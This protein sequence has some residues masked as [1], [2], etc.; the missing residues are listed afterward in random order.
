MT[1]TV[2]NFFET[3]EDLSNQLHRIDGIFLKNRIGRILAH[4]P[5][6]STGL[7]YLPLFLICAGVLC[8]LQKAEEEGRLHG[9]KIY[10]NALNVSLVVCR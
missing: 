1:G 4:R 3:K 10:H 6:E 8:L 7:L 2:G 5:A 9:V